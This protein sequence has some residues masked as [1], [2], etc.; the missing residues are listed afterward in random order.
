[1]W[2]CAASWSLPR[3][4]CDPF[5]SAI[6]LEATFR[7]VFAQPGE[8]RRVPAHPHH[9]RPAAVGRPLHVREDEQHPAPVRTILSSGVDLGT[10]PRSR[11]RAPAA[12]NDRLR[13][14]YS[15][16]RPAAR[17]GRPLRVTD[18]GCLSVGALCSSD[19]A[20]ARAPLFAAFIARTAPSDCCASFIIGYGLRPFPTRS[21]RTTRRDNAQLSKVPAIDVCACMGSST[22]RGPA[23]ARL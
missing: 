16:P 19:S 2:W 21:R 5:G 10:P 17:W 6:D 3:R 4:W 1:M 15:T 11:L 8:A 18:M 9:G 13:L 23:T 12:G 22:P 14:P 7:D 20:G